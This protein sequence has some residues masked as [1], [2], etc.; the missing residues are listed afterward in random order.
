MLIG[1]AL[2]CLVTAVHDSGGL[3]A[4]IDTAQAADKLQMFDWRWDASEMVGWV[5]IVGFLFTNLVPYTTDQTVIQRYLTTR[6]EKQAARSMWLNLAI[7]IP[8]GL[9]FFGLGTALYAYY[10]AHPIE[11][12]LLP[13]KADQL[14]PWYVVNHLPAGVAGVVVAGIFAAAMSSLDSSINSITTTILNDFVERLRPRKSRRSTMRL[15]RTLTLVL[16]VI[17]TGAAMA[18]ATY[19]IKYLF[20]FFQKLLGLFGG[21]MAGVFLLA[22]F[23]RR[24]N[25]R[26]ALC[27]LLSGGAATIAVANFTEI[28]FLL[29]AP[30]GVTSCMLVG[31][32]VSLLSP[33]TNGKGGL[34]A[35]R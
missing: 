21:G 8:T 11:A 9:L 29:Y 27:G 12:A 1:G 32:G 24:T 10:E 26:G 22:A 35:Q 23:T 3:G 30:V 16:G 18:L 25:A 14:V 5:L 17:G 6:D 13:P 2:L 20:D 4:V 31:Y 7:T 34:D 33:A 19:E 15:A 28:N